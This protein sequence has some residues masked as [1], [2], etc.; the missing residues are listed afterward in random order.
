VCSGKDADVEKLIEHR[1]LHHA[2]LRRLSQP[3]MSPLLSFRGCWDRII[4]AEAHAKAFGKLWSDFLEDE[5]YSSILDMNDD[6]TGAICVVPR[7]EGLRG[8]FAFMLGEMLYQL[9]ATLDSA[10]YATAVQ[11]SGQD[12]PPDEEKL[13]FPICAREEDFKKSGWKIGSLSQDHRDF[14]QRVQPYNTPN[15]APHLMIGNV[16]RTLG[17]L[18]HWARIDRHRRLH[19]LGSWAANASPLL[20]LPDGCR[21]V[22][23]VVHQDGLLEHK[24]QIASFTLAG[25]TPGMEVRANPNLTID[26]AVDE[27]PS[28]CADNDTLGARID[29]MSIAVRFVVGWLEAGFPGGG[30][31][32]LG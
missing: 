23:M 10:V 3:S 17:I 27:S 16:N 18:N 15:I 11:K 13:E 7:Y 12:P 5:P 8:E 21:L 29:A 1:H 26:V 22:D 9:R 20:R 14:I 4:R 30:H 32:A 19:V 24:N 31:G 28:P 6:G 2:T 25:F